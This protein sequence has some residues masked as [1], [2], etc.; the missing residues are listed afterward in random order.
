[1]I[2]KKMIPA[3]Y[4][5][6]LDRKAEAVFYVQLPKYRNVTDGM[7]WYLLFKELMSC[8]FAPS[9]SF[10]RSADDAAAAAVC[11]VSFKMLF[12]VSD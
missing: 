5:I 1:M 3:I 12:P 6:L 4:C 7:W 8:F 11:R 10:S 9:A 2:E